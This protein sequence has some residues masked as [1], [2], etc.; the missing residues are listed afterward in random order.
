MIKPK[1]DWKTSEQ[2]YDEL[3]EQFAEQLRNRQ[4]SDDDALLL[5]IGSPGSGK[6]MLNM[7][8]GHLIAR[9]NWSMDC[10]G[11]DAATYKAALNYVKDFEKD[12]CVLNDEA[13]IGKRD[14]IT[15]K[16]KQLIDMF[17]AIRGLNIIHLWCNP[18]AEMMDKFFIKERILGFILVRKAKKQTTVRQYYYFPAKKLLA[19][20]EKYKTL[21]LNILTK[22]RKKYAK[23]GGWFKDYTGELKEE[24]L[25][26]KTARMK[27]KIEML[28]VGDEPAYDSKQYR[29]VDLARKMKVHV[30]TVTIRYRESVE[31]NYLEEG[32]DYTISPVGKVLFSENGAERLEQYIRNRKQIIKEKEAQDEEVVRLT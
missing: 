17:L 10:V 22:V 3:L 23:F 19:I 24:Y 18:S 9:D 13:N 20:L 5:S 8:L 14:A 25:E 26:K 28:D 29:L 16:N 4:Q 15:K 11:F 12:K 1:R 30:N 32:P 2:P 21:D 6:S 31:N 7:H 27:L